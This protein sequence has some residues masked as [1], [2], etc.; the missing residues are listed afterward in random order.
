MSIQP[1]KTEYKGI[2]FDSKSEA[3]F[4]RALDNAGCRWVYHFNYLHEWD[5]LVYP[6]LIT[7]RK[8]NAFQYPCHDIK[9]RRRLWEF[10]DSMAYH[11]LEPRH[12]P[13]LIEYKPR[14]P[15]MTYVRNLTEKIRQNPVESIIVW[16]SFWNLP[17]DA[18]YF[19]SCQY[20][21]SYPVFCS[22]DRKFGWGDFEPM[23]D[24]GYDEPYSYRHNITEMLGI[25]SSHYEEAAGHRFDLLS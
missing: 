24:C 2:V 22:Y 19:S 10:E 21:V 12:S 25:T 20:L 5:F 17:E 7:T 13:M 4:A 18:L 15:T 23:A 16:G 11:C 14:M 1:T 6:G 9:E 3:I 8:T